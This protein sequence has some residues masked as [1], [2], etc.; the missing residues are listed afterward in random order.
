MAKNSIG[1][2]W[3]NEAKN[4]TKYLRGEIELDGEKHKII[5]FKNDHK[6]EDK[7]PDY[8]IF[9]SEDQYDGRKDQEA[10]F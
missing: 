6:K 1:A 7:H 8:R 5:V 10:P 9:Q 4:G 3:L 2:L